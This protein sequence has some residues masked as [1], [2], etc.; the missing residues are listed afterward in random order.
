MRF[1]I[2]AMLITPLLAGL[3]VSPMVMA[4]DDGYGEAEP[5]EQAQD[6][7]NFEQQELERFADAYVEVGEI[8]AD[9]SQRL[10]QAEDPDQAQ[11]VQQ[12]ANDRMIEAIQEQGLEVQDYSEIAAALERDPEMRD[13]V[14][15]L[16]EERE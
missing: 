9:Y 5:L 16:I 11:E 3:A 6:A 15:T 12:E 10:E 8:H 7:E 4:Q 14:V 13:E 1:R 2:S